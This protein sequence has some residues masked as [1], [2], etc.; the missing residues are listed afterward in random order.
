M[1]VSG[2]RKK[3]VNLMSGRGLTVKES[4]RGPIGGENIA[5]TLIELDS[6]CETISL[7]SSE[8]P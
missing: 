1:L 2:D 8:R 3:I 6:G 4:M 7:R 5:I